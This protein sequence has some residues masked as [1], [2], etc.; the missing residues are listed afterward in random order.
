MKKAKLFMGEWLVTYI[1]GKQY[2]LCI[3]TKS[4]IKNVLKVYIKNMQ[5][6]GIEK[7]ELF[8]EYI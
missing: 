3:N 5:Q 4:K 8:K 2:I 1:N 7:I 6:L